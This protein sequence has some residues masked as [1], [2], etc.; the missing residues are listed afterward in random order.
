MMHDA[1]G[2]VI[3]YRELATRLGPNQ[4]VYGLRSQALDDRETPSERTEEMAS[5]YVAAIR[6][7]QSHGPYRLGGNC[8]GGLLAFEAARQLKA[9]GE[10]IAVL[11]L[12][13]TAF[14]T[15]WLRFKVRW[16]WRRMLR[17][18]AR[19][20]LS[21]VS[22]L[23]ARVTKRIFFRIFRSVKR[24]PFRA[25]G[26]PSPAQ[27]VLLA[28]TRALWRYRAQSY[29]SPAIVF[30]VGTPHN[31]RGWKKVVG[32]GLQFVELPATGTNKDDDHIAQPPHV[33]NLAKALRE[34]LHAT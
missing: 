22:G 32:K 17:R 6:R 34:I 25:E 18:S 11:A 3:T 13:D 15:S 19:E 1:Y 21:Y 5:R 7:V 24:S 33:E 30:C 31:H 8:F 2:D 27:T 14:P 29:E 23:A 9:Q 28:N 16:H 26:H 10:E 20:K 4:P 12:I